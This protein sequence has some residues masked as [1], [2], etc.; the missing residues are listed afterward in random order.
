MHHYPDARKKTGVCSALLLAAKRLQ[1]IR[2]RQHR[3]AWV[4]CRL[5]QTH[6]IHEVVH[7]IAVVLEIQ[8]ATQSGDDERRTQVTVTRGG[9]PHTPPMGMSAVVS[10][11]LE[12]LQWNFGSFQFNGDDKSTTCCVK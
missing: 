3:T 10:V 7:V 11:R 1:T 9:C 5:R 12:F 4:P 6:R 8:A 2:H